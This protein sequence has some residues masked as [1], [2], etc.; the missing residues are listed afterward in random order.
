MVSLN[1]RIAIIKKK[2]EMKKLRKH[3]T[4]EEKENSTEAANNETDLYSVTDTEFQREILKILKEL[5][6]NMMK[7]RVEIKANTDYFRKVLENKEEPRKKEN[8]FAEI[9][10]ELKTMKSRMNNAEE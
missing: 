5:R 8:S 10:T 2:N 9:Q 6:V 4:L 7:L 1:S 3:S